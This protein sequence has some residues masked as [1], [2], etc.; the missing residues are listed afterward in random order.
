LG[1][2]YS[3]NSPGFFGNNA[4]TTVSALK[5]IL[6]LSVLGIYWDSSNSKYVMGMGAHTGYEALVQYYADEYG[7]VYIPNVAF[8][9][10]MDSTYTPGNSG[11][12]ALLGPRAATGNV[13]TWRLGMAF[14]GRPFGTYSGLLY[15]DGSAAS[16]TGSGGFMVVTCP[17]SLF[18]YRTTFADLARSIDV[19]VG[20]E[21]DATVKANMTAASNSLK[22]NPD[23][24][25]GALESSTYF[26]ITKDGLKSTYLASTMSDAGIDITTEQVGAGTVGSYITLLN[27]L[28]RTSSM[29][30]LD[31]KTVST[32]YTDDMLT[33]LNNAENFRIEVAT[34]SGAFVFT[35]GNSS[36]TLSPQPAW[37][38]ESI[39]KVMLDSGSSLVTFDSSDLVAARAA[40]D[41]LSVTPISNEDSRL[42]FTPS[43]FMAAG[44]PVYCDGMESD[45]AARAMFFLKGIETPAIR[46]QLR[47][48]VEA[49]RYS[50]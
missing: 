11:L 34:V 29:S 1:G 14:V 26:N 47:G 46:E 31:N 16:A 45:A 32:P 24:T 44:Y 8:P 18:L 37:F 41:A 35:I 19:G 7:A 6:G 9:T 50:A 25:I 30:V 36:G 48:M 12:V 49:L 4:G 21:S 3:Y 20:K 28:V 5:S 17:T 40:L 23:Y 42:C 15:V 27:G 2:N 38:D 33:T 43:D 13:N 39:A 22:S 10:T